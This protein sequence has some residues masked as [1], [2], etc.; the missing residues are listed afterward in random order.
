MKNKY[1]ILSTILFISFS[2][3]ALADKDRTLKIGAIVASSE[4]LYVDGE[5]KTQLQPRINYQ[6]GL[7]FIQGTEAG[8]IILD[9]DNLKITGSVNIDTR[10]IDRGNSAQLS[11]MVTL[12][13]AIDVK[14]GATWRNALGK[15]KASIR[16]D[17]A[18]THN[19]LQAGLEFSKPMILANT[20][21]APFIGA[22]WMSTDTANYY[23]GVSASD[24][25]VGRPAYQANNST[26]LS[27]G[28]KAMHPITKSLDLMGI[29]KINYFDSN[30]T[31]SPIVDKDH[32]VNI[33]LGFQ[34]SF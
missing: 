5:T 10:D 13:R 9:N 30:V 28:I 12:D 2:T 18:G 29:A 20:K 23:Y 15:V 4:S 7:F 14:I 27:V 34:Y 17:I 3:L 32:S 19:G 6:N 22:D 1:S 26:V 33:G 8:G 24:A 31:D 25:K 16:R 21:V 11:D